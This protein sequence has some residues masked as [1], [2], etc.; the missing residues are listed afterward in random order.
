MKCVILTIVGIYL[1][2]L[3]AQAFPYSPFAVN[4]DCDRF[5]RA[6]YIFPA[7]QIQCWLGEDLN[8]AD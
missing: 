1:C 2:V 6:D 7:R 3:F 4:F 8:E 5:R